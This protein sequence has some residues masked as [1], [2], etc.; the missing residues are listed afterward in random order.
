M[1]ERTFI[2]D[3]SPGRHGATYYL[4]VTADSRERAK[5]DLA[6]LTDALKAAFPSAERNLMVSVNNSTVPAP[7][8]LS[9]RI[10][11]GVLAT[12]VLIMLG[13][14]LLLV[15]GAY[16]EGMGR[17]GIFAAM[18]TPFL[19]WILPSSGD[20]E[21]QDLLFG[22]SNTDWK[23]VLL[24]L[25]VTPIAVILGLWLTR[26]SRTAAGKSHRA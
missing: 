22:G 1:E 5:A 15:I 4:S 21:Y 14:Q 23:F 17:A 2:P 24:L 20:D 19:I 10:H 12:L 8:D 13:C 26:K 3:P 11:F 16:R 7:T 6:I 18:V 25:A 9:R